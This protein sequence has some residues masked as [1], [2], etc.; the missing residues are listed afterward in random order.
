MRILPMRESLSLVAPPAHYVIAP[1]PELA[2]SFYSF[3]CII[4]EYEKN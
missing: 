1:A 3:F 2:F 4:I